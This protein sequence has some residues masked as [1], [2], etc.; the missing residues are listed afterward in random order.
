[1]PASFANLKNPTQFTATL[2]AIS[3]QNLSHTFEA[4]VQDEWKP[5]TNLT[6]NL[7]ARYDLQTKIFNEDFTQ[8]RYPTPLPYVDF[9]S[10]GDKNNI[11]PRLGFAWDVRD[12]GRSVLRGGYGIVY[13]NLQNSLL[14]GE[15]TAFQQYGVTI[16]NPSYPD[17]YNGKSPESFVSTAPPNITIGANDLRNPFAQTASLGFSQQIGPSLAIHVDGV[18]SNI[19]DYPNR[20]NINTPDPASGMRPLPQWGQIVQSQP[21]Q[22]SFDYRALLVRLEKRYS[23]RYLYTVSYTLSK[24]E[25]GWTGKDG[26]ATGSITDVFHP[27]RDLGPADTDR[28]HNL[29]ASGSVL[30]PFSL[31]L[32]AVWTLR[33]SLP[34][35]A[36]AGRDLNN[37]GFNTDYVPGTTK[38][39]GDR[40][41]DISLVNVWRAQNGLGPISASQIDST[42]YNRL[43]A[44][45]SKAIAL[46]GGRKLE[47]IGQ[48]F[49]LLGSDN[50]GGVGSGQV[51]NALSDSFGRV[52]S[53]LPRQQAELAVRVVF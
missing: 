53:A 45:L 39:Q 31:Q 1:M 26:N 29:A 4:Y 8:A 6:L 28:R 48:V 23:T 34:F 46:G 30:L 5:L 27:E 11:A 7:G 13:V 17:P 41:L 10:R 2:P 24:Q 47:L 14:D 40:N 43:D 12:D 22:G 33:S 51:T 3:P 49:N 42:R 35:S 19:D 21:A 36:Q 25:D 16:K 52:L 44:R 15:I 50:L 32:G 38:N 18:Y 37:D 9:A 20:V